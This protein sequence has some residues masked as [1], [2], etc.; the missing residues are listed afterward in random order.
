MIFL[1]NLLLQIG[2]FVVAFY[3]KPIYDKRKNIG[4]LCHDHV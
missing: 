2:D 1:P 4:G 3:Q